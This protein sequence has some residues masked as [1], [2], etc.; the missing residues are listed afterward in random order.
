MN[1]KLYPHRL[2][3]GKAHTVTDADGIKF[4][5]NEEQ[6]DLT[7]SQALAFRDKF[8]PIGEAPAALS[9]DGDGDDANGD[10]GVNGDGGEAE[11]DDEDGEDEEELDELTKSVEGESETITDRRRRERAERK[12]KKNKR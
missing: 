8:V 10:D 5:Q 3:P 6:V 11:D 12:A 2:R 9:E 4:L 7:E 1:E